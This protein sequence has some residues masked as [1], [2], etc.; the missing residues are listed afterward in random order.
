M[1]IALTAFTTAMIT[2]PVHYLLLVEKSASVIELNGKPPK[3]G[4]LVKFNCSHS[5]LV[6]AVVSFVWPVNRVIEQLLV[7]EKFGEIP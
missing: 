6:G 7:P 3:S 2:S 5:L 1:T 4:K